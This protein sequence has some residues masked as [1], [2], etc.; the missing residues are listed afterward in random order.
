MMSASQSARSGSIKYVGGAW[1]V[2]HFDAR[3][4]GGSGIG[5]T[6]TAFEHPAQSVRSSAINSNGRSR[7]I[8]FTYGVGAF[9][10]HD[11]G[12]IP[13]VFV[14]LRNIIYY[15]LFFDAQLLSLFK[16][17][18]ECGVALPVAHLVS[19]SCAQNKSAANGIQ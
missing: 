12:L 10:C 5:V 6:D 2:G 3:F 8:Y 14:G 9:G 11:I 7:F 13:F 17:L 16:S 1:S 4:A 15:S 19:R 18:C